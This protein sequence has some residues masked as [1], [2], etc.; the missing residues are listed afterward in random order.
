MTYREG[1][2]KH[3]RRRIDMRCEIKIKRGEQ[4]RVRKDQGGG[5]AMKRR[6]SVRKKNIMLSNKM[7]S[8]HK[9][10]VLASPIVFLPEKRTTQDQLNMIQKVTSEI[11]IRR[12]GTRLRIDQGRKGSETAEQCPK[13]NSL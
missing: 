3:E 12:E 7:H 6:N 2:D 10:Y 11:K 13:K 9:M 8:L 1:E 5:Q 4:T